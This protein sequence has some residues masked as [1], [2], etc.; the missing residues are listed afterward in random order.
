M[1]PIRTILTVLVLTIIVL[2]GF[3][4]KQTFLDKQKTTVNSLGPSVDSIQALSELVTN[5]VYISD[6]LEASNKDYKG[7]WAI[8]GDALI[9]YDLTKV[10]I[11]ENDQE[12]MTATIVMPEPTVISARVD[13]DRS[14]LGSIDGKGF[15]PMRNPKNRAKMM[16]DAMIEAQQLI[17]KAASKP[18]IIENSKQQAR[19]V[20]QNLYSKLGWK[21]T[22]IWKNDSVI[23]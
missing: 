5:R 20:I 4:F 18:K 16:E 19:L 1:A 8:N 14:R 6:I 15:A 23:P 10:E 3:W 21:V 2:S 7:L 17:Q 11:R 12:L 9:S 13:H 22:V